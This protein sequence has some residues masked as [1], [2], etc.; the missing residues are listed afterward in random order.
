MIRTEYLR[1]SEVP[2]PIKAYQRTQLLIFFV[3]FM[4]VVSLAYCAC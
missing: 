2:C 3:K 1:F 4:P